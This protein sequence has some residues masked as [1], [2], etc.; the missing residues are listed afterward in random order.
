MQN[1]NLKFVNV[2]NA[3]FRNCGAMGYRITLKAKDG[4]NVN[5]YETGI[6]VEAWM[7]WKEMLSLQQ[8]TLSH[9]QLLD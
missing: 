3:E 1:A 8:L 4:E 9:N 7:D 6:F 5:V 2:V